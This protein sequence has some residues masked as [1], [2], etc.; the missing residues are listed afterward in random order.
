MENK[1][2]SIWDQFNDNAKMVIGYERA[3]D[4]CTRF[5]TENGKANVE[6]FEPDSNAATLI[7]V[8]IE[9]YEAKEDYTTC[10]K[11][12]RLQ[13]GFEMPEEICCSPEFRD[14]IPTGES[15]LYREKNISECW[16]VIQ[17]FGILALY[18]VVKREGINFDSLILIKIL[19]DYYQQK[20]DYKKCEFLSRLQRKINS[21][22][23]LESGCSEKDNH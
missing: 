8:L 10:A 4:Y 2:K 5:I 12:I 23:R 9:H 18:S 14:F 7:K 17:K 22:N 20:G 1:E 11:L 16:K 21:K 13:K 3:C 15:V 6:E 19:L